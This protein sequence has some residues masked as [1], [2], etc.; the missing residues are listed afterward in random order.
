MFER[1]KA[2]AMDHDDDI[3]QDINAAQTNTTDIPDSLKALRA[4]I[5]CMLIKTYE[6]VS[7]FVLAWI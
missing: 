5:P 6:Q 3:D 4:C 7:C 1:V 2:L